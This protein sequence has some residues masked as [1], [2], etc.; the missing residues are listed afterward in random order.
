MKFGT[1]AFIR[2]KRGE[3]KLR[4][5]SYR[6]SYENTITFDQ[7]KKKDCNMYSKTADQRIN[8]VQQWSFKFLQELIIVSGR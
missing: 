3:E 1:C 2:L 4:R 8:E 7:G 6:F 5:I